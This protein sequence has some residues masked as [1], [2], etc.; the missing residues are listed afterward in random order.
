MKQKEITRKISTLFY[1]WPY[2]SNATLSWEPNTND[3]TLNFLQIPRFEKK[4]HFE[5]E[6]MEKGFEWI[7]G[8]E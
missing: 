3:A 2:F 7:Y 8:H 1:E 5:E 6:K 4:F